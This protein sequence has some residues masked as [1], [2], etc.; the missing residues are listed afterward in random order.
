MRTPTSRSTPDRQPPDTAPTLTDTTLGSAIRARRTAL[1]L[2]QETVAAR[3]GVDHNVLSRIERGV[4]PCRMTEFV[5]IAGALNSN[6]DVLLKL[7]F[8]KGTEAAA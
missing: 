6:P 5:A 1:G 4:R 8:G 2:R 3:S 7:A